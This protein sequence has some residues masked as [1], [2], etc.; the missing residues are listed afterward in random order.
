[1]HGVGYQCVNLFHK[2]LKLS[3]RI[4]VLAPY[5][6]SHAKNITMYASLIRPMGWILFIG[7]V[8]KNRSEKNGIFMI[9]FSAD[10]RLFG[11]R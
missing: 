3:K 5:V 9:F 4:I 7:H 8:D 6:C 10:V 2:Q 1:M 11:Y